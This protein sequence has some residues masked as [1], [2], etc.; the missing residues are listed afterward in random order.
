MVLVFQTIVAVPIKWPFIKLT[1][2]QKASYRTHF[3]REMGISCGTLVDHPHP[4]SPRAD[5]H[6]T[7]SKSPNIETTF[8][9]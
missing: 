1:G 4:S 8:T 2:D 5:L 3:V 6:P 9:V 7:E